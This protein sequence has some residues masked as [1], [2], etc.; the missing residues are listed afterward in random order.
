MIILRSLV[1]QWNKWSTKY[2]HCQIGQRSS[3]W[4]RSFIK[5]KAST[6]KVFEMIQREG[7]VRIRVDGEIYDVSEAPELEK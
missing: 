4:H 2:W 5:R 7:Y 3:C 1:N 6:K